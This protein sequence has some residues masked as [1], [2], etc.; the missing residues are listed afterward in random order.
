MFHVDVL[1]NVT[2][3]TPASHSQRE[4]SF[5]LKIGIDSSSSI[6]AVHVPSPMD[7]FAEGDDNKILKSS[8]HSYRRSWIVLT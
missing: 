8:L 4:R 1:V 6:V 7:A 3:K 2:V 5:T